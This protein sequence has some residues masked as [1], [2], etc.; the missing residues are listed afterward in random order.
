MKLDMPAM[1]SISSNWFH[2]FIAR[3]FSFG[4]AGLRSRAS[5]QTGTIVPLPTKVQNEGQFA[6]C[7]NFFVLHRPKSKKSTWTMKCSCVWCPH[8]SSNF[9]KG[10]SGLRPRTSINLSLN[11][12]SLKLSQSPAVPKDFPSF[13]SFF[14]RRKKE[15]IIPKQRWRDLIDS[16]VPTLRFPNNFIRGKYL[17]KQNGGTWSCGILLACQGIMQLQYYRH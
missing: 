7:T 9:H 17:P 16:G 3:E 14:S 15:W 6:P 2:R 8:S 5:M 10:I 4:R 12:F 11:F 1:S 13:Q